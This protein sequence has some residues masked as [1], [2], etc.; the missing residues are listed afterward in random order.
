MSTFITLTA[1]PLGR[2]TSRDH[3]CQ[4]VFEQ[5]GKSSL[6]CFV[7]GLTR[8]QLV[9]SNILSTLHIVLGCKRFVYTVLFIL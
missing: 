4:H 7:C 8:S 1:V 6:K 5:K 2:D 9:K 3:I